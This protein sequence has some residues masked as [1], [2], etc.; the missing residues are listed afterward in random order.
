MMLARRLP[1]RDRRP[2]QNPAGQRQQD[3]ALLGDLLF[4]GSQEA[5]LLI[6]SSQRIRRLNPAAEA[7]LG[8][9]AHQAIGR[10]WRDIFQL[11]R[12]L[13][14]N[15][16]TN[17]IVRCLFA[18]KPIRLPANTLLVSQHLLRQPVVGNVLPLEYQRFPAALVIM[19][20]QLFAGPPGDGSLERFREH[21]AL[22]AHMFRLNTVGELATGIAHELNQPLT[23]I[24]SYSQ[25]A[26]R[27]IH[28][29]E[30]DVERASEALM[31]TASQARRA[32][33]ILRQLRAFV[34]KQRSDYAPVA[35]NQ[36]IINTLTLLAGPL[37]EHGVQVT[38]HTEPCPPVLADG[39]QIE[40]VLVNL[41]RNA[42]DAMADVP[43]ERRLLRIGSSFQ[44]NQVVIEVADTGPG[45][46]PGVKSR[47][48]TRF[49][50]TKSQGMGLGLNISQ[51]II[52]AAGGHMEALD[53]VPAGALFRI[54]LPVFR[55]ETYR[56][57][58]SA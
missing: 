1:R 7:L 25:A 34:S 16:Q 58:E 46:A 49:Y 45:F 11:E 24:L 54:N 36:V 53:N 27:L 22:L 57:A 12:D 30:P 28:D 56:V 18:R 38:L 9:S 48:F 41:V 17:P 52:E 20:V 29:E 2:R 31:E 14:H 10:G 15:F 5:V 32:G 51:T 33:E 26:I 4:A 55:E 42:I 44:H 43:G 13:A 23:A 19:Q 6:D 8:I 39:I 35:I 37:Q 40:Q 47:L 21:E 50:S 3:D